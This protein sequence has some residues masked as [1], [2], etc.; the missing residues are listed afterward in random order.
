MKTESNMVR[1]STLLF[2]LLAGALSLALFVLK[3]QVQ[4]L[5]D[6]LMHLNRTIVSD[7]QAIHVLKAEWSHLNDPAR[8]RA[9]TERH[10]NLSP[11]RPV[12][13]GSIEDLPEAVTADAAGIDFVTKI[14]RALAIEKET[15]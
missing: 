9:L 7:T 15:P 3:Y 13:L 8:L 1:H 4:D 10:L 12:Q 6:E 11:V 2:M 14:S 5:E